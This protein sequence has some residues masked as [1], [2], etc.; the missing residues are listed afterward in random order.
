MKYDFQIHII[1][2]KLRNFE[3]NSKKKSL[4]VFFF[5]QE[6]LMDDYEIEKIIK[7]WYMQA[8]NKNNCIIALNRIIKGFLNG[9]KDKFLQK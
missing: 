9:K 2:F 6:Y 5:F 7:Y 1:F 8:T 3:I 4:D